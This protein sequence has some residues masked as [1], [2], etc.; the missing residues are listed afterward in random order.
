MSDELGMT[1]EGHVSMGRRLKYAYQYLELSRAELMVAYPK[2]ASKQEKQLSGLMEKIQM[3]QA[4]LHSRLLA[5]YQHKPESELLPIYL[6]RIASG[7]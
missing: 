4:S 1:Y 7:S 3:T 2:S 5:E 6:G